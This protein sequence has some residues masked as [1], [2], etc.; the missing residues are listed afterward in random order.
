MAANNTSSDRVATTTAMLCHTTQPAR[1]GSKT[2]TV[3]ADMT[4]ALPKHKL[5]KASTS[6]AVMITPVEAMQRMLAVHLH[7]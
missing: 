2:S 7:K 3:L 5:V 6:N 4:L 1:N